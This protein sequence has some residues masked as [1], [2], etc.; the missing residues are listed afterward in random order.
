MKDLRFRAWDDL[1]NKIEKF[2]WLDEY[3]HFNGE[4][5]TNTHYGNIISVEQFTGLHDKNGK[6]IFEGDIVK[7]C[8]NESYSCESFS[9]DDEWEFTGKIVYESCMFLIGNK[10]WMPLYDT[11]E[12]ELDVEIIGNINENPELLEV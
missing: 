11:V 1:G 3:N 9:T 7:I 8:G 10:E 2:A 4:D 5:L 12:Y 6:M